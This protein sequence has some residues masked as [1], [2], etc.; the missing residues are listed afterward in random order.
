M[1]FNLQSRQVLLTQ[2]AYSGSVSVSDICVVPRLSLPL[3]LHISSQSSAVGVCTLAD[4]QTGGY[5]IHKGGL[6]S[7]LFPSPLSP[8]F[9]L[10][11]PFPSHSLLLPLEVIQLELEGLGV[12]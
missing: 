5:R 10:L 3:L 8:P 9:Y 2:A 1:C 11:P 12:L 7:I 4:M 6:L